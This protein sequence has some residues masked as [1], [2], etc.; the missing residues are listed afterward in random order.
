MKEKLKAFALAIIIAGLIIF[1]IGCYYAIFK[2]GLPYQDPT[3]E[4]QIKY[5]IHMG[6]GKSLIKCG[7]LTFFI[8]LVFRIIMIFI[9]KKPEQ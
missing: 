9:K 5:S 6:I 4:L 2:A 1:V 7:G 3:L 8:G